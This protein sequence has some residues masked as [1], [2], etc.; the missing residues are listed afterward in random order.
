M[1]LSGKQTGGQ[2]YEF[3]LA[4]VINKKEELDCNYEE[5]KKALTFGF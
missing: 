3:E 1:I 5:V 4:R 2:N